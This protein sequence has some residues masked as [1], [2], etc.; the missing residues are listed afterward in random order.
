MR[1]ALYDCGAHLCQLLFFGM[2]IDLR[3]VG[4]NHRALLGHSFERSSAFGTVFS[5]IFCGIESLGLEVASAFVF[6]L[7]RKCV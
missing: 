1:P 3:I 4:Q 2:R 7:D 5:L 6:H